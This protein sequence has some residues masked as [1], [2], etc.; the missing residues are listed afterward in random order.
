MLHVMI[1]I[2]KFIISIQQND[3]ASVFYLVSITMGVQ[4]LMYNHI[5]TPEKADSPNCDV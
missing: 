5:H 1:A 4:M 2:R 3:N